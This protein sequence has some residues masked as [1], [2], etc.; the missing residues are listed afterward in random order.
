M[1]IVWTDKARQCLAE[2]ETYIKQDSEQAALKIV[3]KLV[4]KTTD[5]LSR[6]PGSGKPGRIHGTRELFFSD[7]PY[8]VVYSADADKV[9]ILAVFHSSQSYRP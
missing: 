9:M 7:M 8:L 2:I 1:Q 3:L 6:Y 4:T 5:Q